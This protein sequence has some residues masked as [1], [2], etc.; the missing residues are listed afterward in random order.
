[1]NDLYAPQLVAT[2]TETDVNGEDLQPG[3]VVEYA[4]DVRNAGLETAADAVLA[5]AVPAGAGY[6]AGSLRIDGASQSD[7]AGD[8][9]GEFAPDTAQGQV[10]VHVGDLAVGASTTVTFRVRVAAA[11]PGGATVANV[12]NLNYRSPA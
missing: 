8:D 10:T 9:R 7:M 6:V 11:I 3:D 4:V 2:K 12:A 5:D 1:A